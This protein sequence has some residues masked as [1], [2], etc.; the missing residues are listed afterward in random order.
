MS[1]RSTDR[2]GPAQDGADLHAWTEV[3][4]PGAGWIGLDPT[5][6]LL[7]GEG[8]IPLAATPHFRSAAPITGTVEPANAA[9]TF[10][11]S[12]ARVS[13]TPRVTRP[14]SDEAWAALDA[15]GE[16]VDA[17]LA[18][19]DV[20]LTMGGEPTFVSIDDYQAP[21][22]TVAALGERKR[23]LAD[24][25]TRRLRERFAPQGLL[26]YGLGKWYPGEAA[27]RWAFALI[28]RRDGKPMWRDADLIARESDR[29]APTADD[30]K[31]FA[32][33]VAAQLGIADSRVQAAY[34]DPVHW[35]L[36]EGK[37]P[38]NVDALDPKLF[39]AA[40]RARMVR[41]FERGLGSPAGYVLP[42]RRLDD[43]WV[44]ETW[45]VRREHLFL[46]PGDLPLGSRLPLGSAAARRACGLSDRR[47]GRSDCRRALPCPTRRQAVRRPPKTASFA[48]PLRRAAR[49]TA[50]RV[51]AVRRGAGRL[52]RGPARRSRQQ[53]HNASCRCTSKAMRRRTI[54]GSMSSR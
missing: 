5:S 14:F 37:L 52:S 36:E 15:L 10:E 51:H 3:F 26:H 24:E 2:R 4:I 44:S 46:L 40:A 43:R 6:G 18:A 21:E 38:V 48:P 33:A 22:W 23:V 28:W 45:D 32:E 16:R 9:F 30:A 17:D 53:R 20:R 31:R 27:P 12:V 34:E 19:N 7:T 13:E 41:A 42:L 54:R 1:R 29:R 39:D 25:L 49:R 50:L 8:H 35:M 47:R 11:M